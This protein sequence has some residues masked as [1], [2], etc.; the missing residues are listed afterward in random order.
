MYRCICNVY[1]YIF[2]CNKCMT[3]M[4]YAYKMQMYYMF[5]AGVYVSIYMYSRCIFVYIY[6]QQ[7]YM[8]LYMYSRSICVYI[9]IAG[10]YV[11]IY[12]Y[13]R[14]ICVYICI[15]GVYVLEDR[16]WTPEPNR[17]CIPS[18]RKECGTRE[19]PDC[20]LKIQ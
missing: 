9:C 10:V 11:S 19:G 6:I 12:M 1:M 4:V 17:S 8:C 2:T 15:A 13:S 3:Y 18:F 14:C 20:G 5:I 16:L 7:V